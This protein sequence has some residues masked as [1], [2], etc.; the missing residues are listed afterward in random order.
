MMMMMTV[1]VLVAVV[2]W[3]GKLSQRGNRLQSDSKSIKIESAGARSVVSGSAFK[4][5]CTSTFLSTRYFFFFHH[6][7]N[8]RLMC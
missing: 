3:L 6:H 2:I 4:A 1:V 5:P 8:Y 7:Y